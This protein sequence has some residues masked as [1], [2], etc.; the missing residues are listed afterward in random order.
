MVPVGGGAVHLV[1]HG[2]GG[3]GAAGDIAGPGAQ[4]S[5]VGPLGPAG[6]ELGHW[7][8]LGGPD[9]AVGLG[10]DE[11]LVVEGQQDVG[12]DKLGLNGGGADG[13]DGLPGED[14]GALGHG[15]DVAGEA[16]GQ[17]IVQK[18]LAEHALGAQVSRYPPRSKWRFWMYW[19]TCSRPAAMAKPP[20]S[21]TLRKNT[22]K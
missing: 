22:S 10:G 17:Q 16:E 9:D 5:A 4:Q 15:P 7:P 3:A 11:G 18:F 19:M 8:A 14:G 13:E 2:A 20:P 21:G 6:A 1:G 12:L